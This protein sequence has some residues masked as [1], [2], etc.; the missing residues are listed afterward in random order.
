MF[1]IC[2]L[3][4][5]ALP[6]QSSL[7]MFSSHIWDNLLNDPA[8]PYVLS[9]PNMRDGDIRFH[10]LTCGATPYCY[11]VLTCDLQPLISNIHGWL[12]HELNFMTF[13]IFF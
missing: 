3:R 12:L 10:A 8:R 7:F 2:E 1:Q 6:V 4:L 5:V 9:V 13:L 11:G